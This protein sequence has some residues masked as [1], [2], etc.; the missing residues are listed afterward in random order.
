MKSNWFHT[1]VF[2][3]PYQTRS[4]GN[5]ITFEQLK[6]IQSNGI[7]EAHSLCNRHCALRSGY[8]I[9]FVIGPS[10]DGSQWDPC[11]GRV[12]ILVSRDATAHRKSQFH[13]HKQLIALATFGTKNCSCKKL[14]LGVTMQQ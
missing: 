13:P 10:V 6:L 14:L 11:S 3:C 8:T 5:L 7:D 2:K 4:I 1:C 9:V 12:A